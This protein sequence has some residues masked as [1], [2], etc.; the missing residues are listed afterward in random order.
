VTTQH[1]GL[2]LP[3]FSVYYKPQERRDVSLNTSTVNFILLLIS[4]IYLHPIFY[5]TKCTN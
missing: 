5:P 3:Q 2:Q 1:S 4:C